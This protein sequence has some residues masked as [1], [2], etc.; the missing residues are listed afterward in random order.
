[1]RQSLWCRHLYLHQHKDD[2][3]MPKS[4]LFAH[5]FICI[6]LRCIM[7]LF[8]NLHLYVCISLWFIRSYLLHLLDGLD[9]LRIS[10]VAIWWSFHMSPWELRTLGSASQSYAYQV[11]NCLYLIDNEILFHHLPIWELLQQCIVG[12]ASTSTLGR[13]IDLLKLALMKSP[14]PN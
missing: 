9:L 5:S 4:N 10:S 1:M 13:Y 8:I 11:T 2:V 14:K 3:M 6:N 7:P 12:F